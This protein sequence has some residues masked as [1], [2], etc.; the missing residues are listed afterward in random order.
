VDPDVEVRGRRWSRSAAEGA[1]PA[2]RA[3]F[4]RLG[5]VGEPALDAGPGA[6]RGA[7]VVSAGFAGRRARRRSAPCCVVVWT[8][9]AGALG[10]RRCICLRG[11]SRRRTT[12]AEGREADGEDGRRRCVMC[13]SQQMETRLASHLL[14]GGAAAG[15]TRR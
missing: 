9:V 6:G 8:Y 5:G 10:M 1:A 12:A 2:A 3:A 14:A 15:L 7:V 11:C 13:S 4:K